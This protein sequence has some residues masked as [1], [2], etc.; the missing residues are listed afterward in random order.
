MPTSIQQ[1]PPSS[2]S[3]VL[4]RP[5]LSKKPLHSPRVQ[6]QRSVCRVSRMMTLLVFLEL[7]PVKCLNVTFSTNPPFSG[8]TV[9]VCRIAYGVLSPPLP[10]FPCPLSPRSH[11]GSEIPVS[12]T[13]FQR[14][15][16]Q[17]TLI[18]IRLP[19]QVVFLCLWLKCT[20]CTGN[21]ILDL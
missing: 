11:Q 12:F 1:D 21:S 15:F 5:S 18:A 2:C 16:G 17:G 19:L 3:L 4:E 8:I 9:H 10:S 14:S 20:M 6:D 7:F 13:S